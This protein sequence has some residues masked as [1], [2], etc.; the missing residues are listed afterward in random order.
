MARMLRE[1][2]GTGAGTGAGGQSPERLLSVVGNERAEIEKSDTCRSMRSIHSLPL[3]S[4]QS[5]I[6]S[7][8]DM[9]STVEIMSSAPSA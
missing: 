2:R 8:S 3:M 4:S 6:S 9:S 5:D 1:G 7:Q